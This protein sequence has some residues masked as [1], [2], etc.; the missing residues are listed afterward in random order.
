MAKPSRTKLKNFRSKIKAILDQEMQLRKDVKH[1]YEQFMLDVDDDKMGQRLVR[2]A[3]FQI[4]KYRVAQLMQ[5]RLE[6]HPFFT[7]SPF[8]LEELED[9]DD[10]DD[11]I[12]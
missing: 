12:I 9:G 6:F 5:E 1:L 10:D 7:A 3:Y 2:Q 4:Q 8:N 11:D